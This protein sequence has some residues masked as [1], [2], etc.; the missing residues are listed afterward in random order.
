MRLRVDVEKQ[1][2]NF[3]LRAK[4]ET[5]EGILALLG[6][7][8]CGK[9]MTLK[10]IAGIVRPDR[11]RIELDGQVLFDSGRRI[12]LPPQKRRVGYLFQ[13]YA[14]FPNMTARQN[15]LA[16]ARRLPRNERQAAADDLIRCLR[17]EGLE[18]KRPFQLSGGQQQRVALARILASRP[19]VILL[20][21]PFSALD[22]FLKWQLESELMETLE[23][24]SGP[25]VWVSHD[26]D[27]VYRRC[28]KVCV[29]SNGRTAPVEDMKG[30][31]ASPETVTAARLSGCKNYTALRTDGENRI[32]LPEWGVALTVSRPV[33][34]GATVLGI[35]S[36]YIGPEVEGTEN[37]FLCR[38]EAVIEN[39]FSTVVLVRPEGGAADCPAIRLEL[40][41]EVWQRFAGAETLEVGVRP[42]D[43][44]LLREEEA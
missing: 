29:M 21:E 31:F 40:E 33:P 44:L 19:Q 38:V 30:L 14:L 24:F 1:L 28:A 16:G 5:S 43:L 25:V 12:D 18:G 42:E 36:H 17:L 22:S 8:G 9:S 41:K 13:Q 32:V 3:H 4:F 15:I 6:A 11:G 10:C 23:T 2:G 37:R 39:V 27:E 34:E 35:R 20:D 26:R 7:S